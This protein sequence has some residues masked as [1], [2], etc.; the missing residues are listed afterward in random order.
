MAGRPGIFNNLPEIGFRRQST[1]ATTAASSRRNGHEFE[2]LVGDAFRQR[3]FTVTG[4]GGGS[5]GGLDLGL[6]KNGERYLVWCKHWRKQQVDIIVIRELS[7][8]MAAVGA[9]GGFV[10]T[11]G[12][13][14][15]EARELARHTHIGLIDGDALEKLIGA[16]SPA[17]G[18]LQNSKA[19]VGTGS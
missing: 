9:H 7:R 16:A 1:A 12:H 3:G 19:M 2:R 11:A 14:T 15:K 18:F 6:T 4:F 13:F 5:H 17:A 8:A 10:V